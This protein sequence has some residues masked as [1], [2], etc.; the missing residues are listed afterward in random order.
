[1][2]TI[3]FPTDFSKN[4]VHASHYAAMLAKLYDANLVLL[5]VHHITM[6]PQSNHTFEIKNAISLSQKGATEDLEAFTE[7]FI[8]DSNLPSERITQRVGYGFTAEKIVEVART[9]EA[10]MIVIGTQG[11]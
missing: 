3:L 4:A 11:A 9:L 8:H 5:H 7:Q 6:V 1:M 10:D 2:K